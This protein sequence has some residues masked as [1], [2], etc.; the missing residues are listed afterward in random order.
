MRHLYEVSLSEQELA[1]IIASLDARQGDAAENELSK[2]LA[3][4]LD[5]EL[6]APYH[7]QV[8]IGRNTR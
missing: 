8:A 3:K 6:W 7:Q 5:S 4:R 1:L 2:R